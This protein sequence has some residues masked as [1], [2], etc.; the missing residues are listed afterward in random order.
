MPSARSSDSVAPTIRRAATIASGTPVA[1]ATNGTVRD[2]LGLA[3]IT[4]TSL[5]PDEPLSESVC[6]GPFPFRFTAN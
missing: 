6:G 2:A 5:A 3:S 4:N 1:L